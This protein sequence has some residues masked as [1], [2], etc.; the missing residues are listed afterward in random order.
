VTAEGV[1]D[2]LEHRQDLVK[3]NLAPVEDHVGQALGVGIVGEEDAQIA[4]P[5]L[6]SFAPAVLPDAGPS[7]GH[8]CRSIFAD[9]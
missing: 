6:V 5:D 7:P 3:L 2:F 8:F 1:A 4:E 9:E